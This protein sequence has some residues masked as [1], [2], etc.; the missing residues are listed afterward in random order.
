M[1]YTGTNGLGVVGLGVVFSPSFSILGQTVKANI[2]LP[3]EYLAEQAVAVAVAQL[4][5]LIPQLVE[6]VVPPA[7][8]AALP[9]AEGYILNTLWPKVKPKLRAEVDLALAKAGVKASGVV[10]ETTK[11]ASIIGGML[12]VGMIG[13]AVFVVRRR[14][15]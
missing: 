10:S 12:I 3:V 8:N 14:K 1:S 4:T 13:A 9:A 15:G 2:D 7:M 11:K 5:P 6:A